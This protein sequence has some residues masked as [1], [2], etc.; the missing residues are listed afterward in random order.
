MSDTGILVDDPLLFVSTSIMDRDLLA[1]DAVT[2]WKDSGG[3]IIIQN[4][5]NN[6]DS[7]PLVV[8]ERMIDFPFCSNFSILNDQYRPPPFRSSERLQR[9]NEVAIRFGESNDMITLIEGDPNDY[10]FGLFATS[11]I[12]AFLFLFFS[13]LIIYFKIVGYKHVGFWSGRFIVRNNNHN[14]QQAANNTP[15]SDRSHASMIKAHGRQS[16]STS[17]EEN[18]DDLI[19]HEEHR[20]DNDLDY[21][22][23][24]GNSREFEVR[25]QRSTENNISEAEAERDLDNNSTTSGEKFNT[26]E[27][28]SSL[29]QRPGEGE[30]ERNEFQDLLDTHNKQERRIFRTRVAFSCVT[31]GTF[32]SCVLF[33]VYGSRYVQQTL[34]AVDNGL[35]GVQGLCLGGIQV[36]DNYLIRQQVA[37]NIT[38]A[39]F[40]SFNGICPNAFDLLC[41]SFD[42][43]T[44]TAVNCDFDRFPI[45]NLREDFRN[46]F[47]RLYDGAAN[48]VVDRL[49]GVKSDLQDIYSE[50]DAF[51][52][53]K[54]QIEWAFWV[55]FGFTVAVCALCAFNLTLIVMSHYR[56]VGGVFKFIRRRLLFPVL[57]FFVLMALI[58]ALAFLIAAVGASDFCIHTPDEKV[59]AI[60]E[61]HQDGMGSIV[62]SLAMYYV[63][64]CNSEDEPQF[65]RQQSNSTVA[66]L[67]NI[68][69]FLASLN[70][71]VSEQEWQEQ[72]GND[73]SVVQ[74][75]LGALGRSFCVLTLTIEDVKRYFW[76]RNWSP[77]YVTFVH[78]AICYDAQTGLAWVASSMLCIVGFSMIALSLRAAIFEIEQE[79]EYLK[80]VQGRHL[81]C[82]RVVHCC[83]SNDSKPMASLE[84]YSRQGQ[85]KNQDPEQNPNADDERGNVV[86]ET[87]Y[88]RE[89]YRPE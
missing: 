14:N 63:N 64:G 77:V 86:D 55:S 29:P 82:Q 1:D 10:V 74:T 49:N 67:D 81:L 40:D 13:L 58:F 59:S 70:S 47:T 53:G 65:F 3:N 46:I 8:V 31:V 79:D 45:D 42:D 35:R 57:I 78:E 22:L 11:I 72:C 23:S 54:Q 38:R 28:T 62:Y 39:Q 52:N 48:L 2:P 73:L 51:I 16:K 80:N 43:S 7:L 9:T 24:Q 27:P 15:S 20:G 87:S 68:N 37:S 44:T 85:T 71:T 66:I 30:L 12:I 26:E 36:I 25:R 6:N 89:S 19:L 83:L 60:L 41:E 33:C 5:N 17:R 69:S 4:N 88:S 18:A 56:K 32:V 75:L 76:C 50:A 84:D 61:N 21:V 34:V